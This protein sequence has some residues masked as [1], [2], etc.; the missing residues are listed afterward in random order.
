MTPLLLS[1]V[2]TGAEL[3]RVTLD[4]EDRLTYRTGAARDIAEGLRRMMAGGDGDEV[5]DVDLAGALAGWSN[6]YLLFR[7]ADA[8]DAGDGAGAGEASPPQE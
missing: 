8:D 1:V 6:G 5:S 2:A 3:D 4:D 7:P